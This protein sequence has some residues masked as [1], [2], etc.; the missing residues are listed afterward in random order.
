MKNNTDG[1]WRVIG[2]T[3]FLKWLF[4]DIK[5]IKGDRGYN[6]LFGFKWG[7]FTILYVAGKIVFKYDDDKIVDRVKFT[8]PDTIS[9]RFYFNKKFKGEFTRKRIN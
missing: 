5:Y 7:W 1:K 8:D 9:G 6:R 3:G 4:G 2:K